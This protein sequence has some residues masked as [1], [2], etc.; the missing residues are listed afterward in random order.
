VIRD[1][2]KLIVNWED[3][4][5]RRVKELRDALAKDVKSVRP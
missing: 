3:Q 1:A 5:R 2:R 4:A